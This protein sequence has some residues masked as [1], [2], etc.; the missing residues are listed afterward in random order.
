MNIPGAGLF[1]WMELCD[2]TFW[3]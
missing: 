3:R 1:D 2:P